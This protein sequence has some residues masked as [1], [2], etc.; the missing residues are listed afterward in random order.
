VAPRSLE[1]WEVES[2][3]DLVYLRE[4]EPFVPGGKVSGG[5]KNGDPKGGKEV[6]K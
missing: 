1:R 3:S 5:R 2:T 6:G 4:R